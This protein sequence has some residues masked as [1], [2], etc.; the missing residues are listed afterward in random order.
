MTEPG[1]QRPGNTSAA[2]DQVLF[3]VGIGADGWHALP[4]ASQTAIAT[5]Q[6]IVGG[7]RQL[8]LIPLVPGQERRLWPKPLL[9]GLPGL[10]DEL[11]QRSVTVV[12]SGDPLLS[13]IG[14]TLI[15]LLGA[16]RVRVLPAISSVSLAGARMG[17]PAETYDVVTVV[18]R[19]PA[20]VLRSVSP[21]RRLIVLSSDES[22][23]PLVADLLTGAGYGPSAL[24]VLCDLGSYQEARLDTVADRFPATTVPRLNVICVQCVPRATAVLLPT[25]G[26]LP[27]DAFE[28]DGQLTKRDAR[29]SALARLAPAPGQLLWD[30]GAGAGSVAIEWA[31]TDPR[32]RAIAVERDPVRAERISVNA[33]RLGVPTVTVVTGSAPIHLDGLPAPDAV[34]IGGGAGNPGVLEACWRAMKLG[35][36][37]VVHGVTLETQ[38]LLIEGQARLGGELLRLSVERVEPLGSFRGWLPARPIVQWSMVKTA[39][40]GP[41]PS[42]GPARTGASRGAEPPL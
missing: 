36:R 26:G 2:N 32:C 34:F 20:A 16:E 39:H 23:P 8:E 29:A 27:D 9:A 33:T 13:G 7:R 35:A 37:M 18:G 4:R 3:V 10:L 11:R 42:A 14:S 19:N 30:V 38:S 15:D 22:T 5:A 12:A 21:G 24:T 17:W 25:V 6:V 28:H 40:T 31:R 41:T 1:N